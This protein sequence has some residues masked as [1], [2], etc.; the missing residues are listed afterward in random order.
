MAAVCGDDPVFPSALPLL[1]AGLP[2]A[3]AG[4]VLGVSVFL[5]DRAAEES[6]ADAG[7][8]LS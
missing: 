3:E 1:A 5:A 7:A 4:A 6:F 2:E 8:G